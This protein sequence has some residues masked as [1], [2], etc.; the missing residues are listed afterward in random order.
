MERM[1]F[2]QQQ[3]AAGMEQK[4]QGTDYFGRLW[5]EVGLSTYSEDR[6]SQL[7]LRDI[8]EIELH[9][10]KQAIARALDPAKL[11]PAHLQAAI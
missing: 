10:I 5:C 2:D 1:N 8:G 6:L 7:K 4:S 9:V 3:N 11:F